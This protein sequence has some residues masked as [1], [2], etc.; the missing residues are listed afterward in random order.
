VLSHLILNVTW[1]QDAKF[2][3]FAQDHFYFLIIII[4]CLRDIRPDNPA[5]VYTV[6]VIVKAVLINLFDILPKI[7][8]V[9]TPSIRP[10]VS[11]LYRISGIRLLDKPDIRQKQY[12]AHP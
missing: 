7:F 8:L 11:G 9:I 2:C 1:I 6:P 3:C 10:D 4:A 12:P 5:L